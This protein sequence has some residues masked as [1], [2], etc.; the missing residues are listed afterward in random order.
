[1][2]LGLSLLVLI[3]SLLSGSAQEP[4]LNQKIV[5]FCETNLDQKVGNGNCYALAHCALIDAGAKPKF[6]DYPGKGD[7]VW[8]YLVYYLERDETAV[9]S[10][11]KIDSILP[12]D[13]IQFRD[14]RFAEKNWSQSFGHHTAVIVGVENG[15]K[16]LK[17]LQQNYN[18]K[19]VVTALT[20]HPMALEKG[21]FRIYQPLQ[22]TKKHK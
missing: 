21:W 19:N 22:A 10:S 11:G 15:G 3:F 20:I 14:C 4:L 6:D 17:I 16:A 7:Y 5:N 1:M 9:K 12:G 8:G 18:G 13:V 2:G